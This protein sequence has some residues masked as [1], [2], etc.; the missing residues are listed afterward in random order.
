MFSVFDSDKMTSLVR[1]MA[2]QTLV[3]AELKHAEQSRNE[4]K[5]VE[6]SGKNSLSQFW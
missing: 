5:R 4:Q 6:K 2:L 1:S 3:L